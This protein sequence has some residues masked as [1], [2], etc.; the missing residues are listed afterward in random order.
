[1][2]PS[3]NSVL[4]VGPSGVRRST[5]GGNSFAV[6]R[7]K[8][9]TGLRATN[10]DRAGTALLAFGIKAVAESTNG[11][12]RW[13]RLKLPTKK[14]GVRDVDFL[15]AKHGYLLDA[16][17]RLW[18]TRN[19]GR[20]WTEIGTLGS[21]AGARLAFSSLRRGF[22][23]LNTGQLIGG[24]VLRTTDGG[25]SW[26]PQI[27]APQR[28]VDVIAPSDGHAYAVAVGT[29]DLLETTT[30]G[31]AGAPSTLTISAKKRLAKPGFVTIG[32]KLSGASGGERVTV[33]AK[34]DGRSLWGHFDATVASNGRFSVRARLT[35][36]ATFVAQWTGDATHA[37]DGTTA[38]HIAVG[39]RR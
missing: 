2:A 28:P 30:G 9:L 12:T 32:G 26:H 24:Q 22:V 3:A 20:R 27:V 34:D 6:V 4:L 18:V 14:G 33:Y 25:K 39:K 21:T 38:L 13:A 16:H 29:G 10:V 23:T 36:G 11:G 7:S 15:D 19:G 17:G 8:A 35:R 5:D 37:G 31:D 1:V